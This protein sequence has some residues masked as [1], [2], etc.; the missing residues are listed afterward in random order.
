MGERDRG[1][2]AYDEELSFPDYRELKDKI[3]PQKN[4]EEYDEDDEE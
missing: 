2:A 4:N 1:Y 3:N